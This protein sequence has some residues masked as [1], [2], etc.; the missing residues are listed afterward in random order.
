MFI[1]QN[2]KKKKLIKIYLIN[3]QITLIV[4][5]PSSQSN[6]KNKIPFN[7]IDSKSR[8]KTSFPQKKTSKKNKQNINNNNNEKDEKDN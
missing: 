4:K 3:A 5:K 6:N 8:N 2:L 7:T 1:I